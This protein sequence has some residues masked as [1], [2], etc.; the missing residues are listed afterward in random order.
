M[1][2]GQ[3]TDGLTQAYAAGLDWLVKLDKA[4]FA[5]KPELVW[6]SSRGDYQCLVGLQPSDPALVPPEASQLVDQSGRIIGRVTSSRFSPTLRRSICMG[7]V[8]PEFAGAGSTVTVRLPDGRIVPATVTAQ[9]A[10]F[11]PKGTR[12][13]G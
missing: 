3:D 4:D 11:D 2:V 1:I 10:H 9:L 13:H 6:Q 12:L 7:F 5:G 8:P